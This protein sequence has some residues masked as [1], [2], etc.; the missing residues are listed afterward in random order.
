MNSLSFHNVG[1]RNWI[2]V[3]KFDAKQFIFWAISLAIQWCLARFKS[4]PRIVSKEATMETWVFSLRSDLSV[5]I[6]FFR[7]EIQFFVYKRNSTFI[8]GTYSKQWLRRVIYSGQRVNWMTVNHVTLWCV[9]D[10]LIH[11]SLSFFCLSKS[12]LFL[13]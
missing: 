4:L 6:P 3:S 11:V 7:L 13:V 2:Q 9:Y 1:S 10:S 5:G 8:L 12:V